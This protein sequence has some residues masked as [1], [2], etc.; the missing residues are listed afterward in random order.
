MCTFLVRSQ[1]TLNPVWHKKLV[2]EYKFEERQ[3]LQFKVFDRDST[4][5]ELQV[6]N[7]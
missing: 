4:S 3:V 1:D 6:C 2:L 5:E 7:S